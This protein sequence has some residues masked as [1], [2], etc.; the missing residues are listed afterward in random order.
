MKYISMEFE[1]RYEYQWL[2]KDYMNIHCQKQEVTH[3]GVR[4]VDGLWK[5]HKPPKINDVIETEMIYYTKLKDRRN[6]N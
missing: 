4:Y 1:R 6:W 3:I 2:N 5:C